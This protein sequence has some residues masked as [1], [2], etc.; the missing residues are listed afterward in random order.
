MNKIE[1][2]NKKIDILNEKVDLLC[3]HIL[4]ENEVKEERFN[5]FSNEKFKFTSGIVFNDKEPICKIELNKD[6]DW[7]CCSEKR[8][9]K[10]ALEN[11]IK[12]TQKNLKKAEEKL[13]SEFRYKS[14]GVTSE[15]NMKIII[16]LV[17]RV[18][19]FKQKLAREQEELKRF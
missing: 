18:I 13:L 4:E 5:E 3:K 8:T 7:I 12:R 10:K 17:D 14:F 15:I 6:N 9:I 19:Y 11:R 2:L 1:I 16:E